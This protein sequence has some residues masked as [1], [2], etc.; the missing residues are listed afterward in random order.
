V[1]SKLSGEWNSE[2]RYAGKCNGRAQLSF[3]KFGNVSTVKD[4]YSPTNAQVIV[5]KSSIKMYI[6]IAIL[7]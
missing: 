1:Y 4:F 2:R 3:N 7:R 6:K 5:L